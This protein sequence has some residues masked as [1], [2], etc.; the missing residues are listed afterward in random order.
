MRLKKYVLQF[1][2]HMT[3]SQLNLHLT[4]SLVLSIKMQANQLLLSKFLIFSKN[5]PS[6]EIFWSLSVV[7]FLNV[8]GWQ[9]NCSLRQTI[10]PRISRTIFHQAQTSSVLQFWPN[11]KRIHSS[12]W[13]PNTWQKMLRLSF[14]ISLTK[15]FSKN[16][17]GQE[18]TLV[19]MTTTC[20]DLEMT[21]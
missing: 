12:A 20:F 4:Q 17:S 11:P 15:M 16:Q 8:R 10:F 14:S 2:K 6:K 13:L 18:P 7:N 1:E 5:C 9:R 21:R 19:V 3:L